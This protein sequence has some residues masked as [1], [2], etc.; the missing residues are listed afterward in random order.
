MDLDRRSSRAAG[1]DLDVTLMRRRIAQLERANETLDRHARALS[2][3]LRS[4]IASTI[5]GLRLLAQF[6]D[7]LSEQERAEILSRSI[8]RLGE[9]VGQMDA[10]LDE[11]TLDLVRDGLAPADAAS[12]LTW[13]L[14][15]L[16]TEDGDRLTVLLDEVELVLARR[17]ALRQIVQNIVS[18]T[19]RHNPGTI[20][21]RLTHERRDDR[22][23]LHFD[24]NGV[25]LPANMDELV[26]TQQSSGRGTGIGM[27]TI[28]MAM[29]RMGGSASWGR[30]PLGGARI[31]LDFAAAEPPRVP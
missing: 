20:S 2:H 8:D 29:E 3:D 7:R 13:A 10:L 14:T 25:G 30:S 17:V 11:A 5:S 24:D 9:L 22:I 18:N 1:P 28:A 4:P 23:L 6:G 12:A 26:A 19:V 31:T 27:T 21:L 15:T 16:P